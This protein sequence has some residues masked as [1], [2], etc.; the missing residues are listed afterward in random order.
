M[1]T[2]NFLFLLFLAPLL[3]RCNN[4]IEIGK[5]DR[6]IITG[7]PPKANQKDYSK[8]HSIKEISIGDTL[9]RVTIKADDFAFYSIKIKDE[10]YKDED[11]VIKVI[12]IGEEEGD[13]DILISKV[14][15]Q[16]NQ[17]L[18]GGKIPNHLTRQ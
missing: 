2:P 11:L 18:L 3:L 13:P 5:V 15:K 7:P 14:S 8:D 17:V 4:N 16:E 6:N 1:K 10:V 9:D 12:P